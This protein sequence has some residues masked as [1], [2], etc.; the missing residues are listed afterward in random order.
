MTE[1]VTVALP[2]RLVNVANRREHYRA[3]A[4]RVQR[5]RKAVSKALEGKSPP[6]VPVTLIL[7]R[8]GWACLDPDGLACATKTVV[9]QVAAW[10]GIDDRHPDLHVQL[11][12]RT[13][14]E[15]VKIQT[16]R[17][18]LTKAKVSLSI[19]IRSWQP[20]DGTD[21]LRVLARESQR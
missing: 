14:R 21:R 1:S 20:E 16:Q 19:T 13:T 5:E 6:S 4:N 10:L 15:R 17:G 12:Q 2:L 3:R 7:V 11:A 9:D 18:V 8:T